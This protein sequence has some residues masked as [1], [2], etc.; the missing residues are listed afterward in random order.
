M[1]RFRSPSQYYI[2]PFVGGGNSIIEVS[3]LRIGA[4]AFSP[5]IQALKLIRDNVSLL[6]KDKAEFSKE[7]YEAIKED[8]YHF[9]HGYIG[10]TQSF[11]ARFYSGWA[12]Y[13]RPR[14]PDS[15]RGAY[16]SALKQSSKLQGVQL[17][18]LPYN[19]LVLPPNSI[20]YCDIPYKD[21]TGYEASFSHEDFFNWTRRTA[22]LHTVFISE[23]SAP[24]DFVC[25]WNQDIAV[26]TS[27]DS[28]KRKTEK[29]F[30]YEGGKT[31]PTLYM[32]PEERIEQ[33]PLFEL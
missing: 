30:M 19:K 33:P 20:I 12:G 24:P 1:T 6:P 17:Y 3:G 2:E 21:T 13:Q 10:F 11:S 14:E 8:P 27:K 16:R 5:T 9:L 7:D 4:D 31:D 25:V 32:T 23:Y 15:I 29:L 28:Q 18:A 26:Y 22:K